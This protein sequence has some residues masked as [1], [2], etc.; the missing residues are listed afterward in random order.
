MRFSD[1]VTV[2]RPATSDAYGNPGRSWEVPTSIP[3][4]GFLLGRTTCFMPPDADVRQ[5]DR[6]VI[7]GVTYDVPDEPSVV[8]SPSKTVI[9]IV[10]VRK[11]GA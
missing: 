6:L 1:A 10:H 11:V 9:T 7:R 3:S 8:R 2:L 4:P 5:G